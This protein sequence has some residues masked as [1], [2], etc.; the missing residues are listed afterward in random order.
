MNLINLVK[1]IKH[2]ERR[3][4]YSQKTAWDELRIL[5]DI[6]YRGLFYNCSLFAVHRYLA[7]LYHFC[8]MNQNVCLDIVKKDQ[9]CAIAIQEKKSNFESFA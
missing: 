8:L 1:V 9:L 3:K 6:A 2:I 5:A 4:T 7:T